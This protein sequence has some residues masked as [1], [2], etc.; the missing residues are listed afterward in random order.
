M[1]KSKMKYVW[2]SGLFMIGSP[3]YAKAITPYGESYTLIEETSGYASNGNIINYIVDGEIKHATISL[4]LSTDNYTLTPNS[5]GAVTILGT[6]YDVS[7]DNGVDYIG[8]VNTPKSITGNI[9]SN[10]IGNTNN[11]DGAAIILSSGNGKTIKGNFISNFSTGDGAGIYNGGLGY[12]TSIQGDFIDNTVSSSGSVFGGAIYNQG[13]VSG[14]DKSLKIKGIFANNKIESTGGDAKGGA[15]YN[16]YKPTSSTDAQLISITDSIFSNNKAS[17]SSAVTV[18]GGAIYHTGNALSITNTSFIGNSIS[19]I[20]AEARGGAISIYTAESKSFVISNSY[21]SKNTINISNEGVKDKARGGAIYLETTAL[22]DLKITDTSFVDNFAYDGA[23]IANLVHG[24]TTTIYADQKDVLFDNMSTGVNSGIY[25]Q[26]DSPLILNANNEKTLTIK[27]KIVSEGYVKIGLEINKNST[28]TGTILLT[29][30]LPT[31]TEIDLNYGTLHLQDDAATS[32][33][34]SI[35]TNISNQAILSTQ[36]S[37]I[38]TLSMTDLLA[39]SGT[40]LNY[41]FDLNLNTKKSDILSITNA[42]SAITI[43]ISDI[44][45]LADGGNATGIRFIEASSG[46]LG[47]FTLDTNPLTVNTENYEYTITPVSTTASSGYFSLNVKQAERVYTLPELIADSSKASFSMTGDLQPKE[48]LGT[49]AGANR[50]FTINGNNHTLSGLAENGSTRL[51]G[52]VTDSKNQTLTVNSLTVQYYT[53][54]A[55]IK[56]GDTLNLQDVVF[57]NNEDDI[58]NAGTVN[59]A[60]TNSFA[61]GV[62]GT[63]LM[64]ISSGTTNFSSTAGLQQGNLTVSS[65]A[66]LKI[67]PANLSITNAV[68]NNGI[69]DFGYDGTLTQMIKGDGTLKV[70]ANLTVDADNLFQNISTN[71]GSVN[72]TGGSLLKTIE[73]TTVIAS[74]TVNSPL[75]NF[76]GTLTN[77]ATLNLADNLTKNIAG[78]GTTV[79]QSDNVEVTTATTVAGTLDLNNK[80]L[81]MQN[82]VSNNVLTIGNLIGTGNLKIDADLT[83]KNADYLSLSGG[84]GTIT[85][86]DISI[87]NP[88]QIDT[89]L[90]I[91]SASDSSNLNFIVDVDDKEIAGYTYKFTTNSFGVLSISRSIENL[92]FEDFITGTEKGK[93]VLIFD[94]SANQSVTA[95]L[96]TNRD[97]EFTLNMNEKSLVGEDNNGITVKSGDEFHIV[98]NGVVTGFSTALTNNGTLVIQNITFED[99]TIDISN[100]G[101]LNLTGINSFSSGITGTGSTEIKSGTTTFSSDANLNQTNLTI[102]MGSILNVSSNNLVISGTLTNNGTLNLAGNLTKDISGS[103]TTV[104]Q[105]DISIASNISISGTLNINE[106]TIDMENDPAVF[107]TLTVGVMTGTGNLKIDADLNTKETDKINAAEFDSATLNLT[108]IHISNGYAS[109]NFLPQDDY[110]TVLTNAGSLVLTNPIKNQFGDYLYTFENGTT[111]GKLKVTQKYNVLTL[112]DYITGTEKGLEVSGEF[113]LAGDINQTSA[114]T[115]GSESSAKNPYTIAL[116]GYAINGD[117]QNNDGITV[118]SGMELTLYGDPTSK[119]TISNFYT[120]LINSGTLN[121]SDVNFTGNNNDIVNNGTLNISGV[122]SFTTGILSTGGGITNSGVVNLGYSGTIDIDYL[123]TGTLNLNGNFTINNKIYNNLSVGSGYT[124]QIKPENLLGTVDNNGTI[125]LSDGIL[126]QSLNGKVII[127]GTVET[128]LSKLTGTIT[129]NGILKLNGDLTK[130]ILGTLGKT[131]LQ[132]ANVNVTNEVKIDGVLDMNNKTLNMA[133]GVAGDNLTIGSFIGTGTL[134]LDVDLTGNLIDKITISDGSQ[135]GTNATL[136]LSL[137]NL[138]NEVKTQD[139][140]FIYGDNAGVEFSLDK[141]KYLSADYQYVASINGNI[142]RIVSSVIDPGDLEIT[143]IPN[144]FVL[145]TETV[146]A[147]NFEINGDIIVLFD[148]PDNTGKFYATR[149]IEIKEKTHLDIAVNKLSLVDQPHIL[150]LADNNINVASVARQGSSGRVSYTISHDGIL[151]ITNVKT[152]TEMVKMSGGS[153]RQAKTAEAWDGIQMNQITTEGKIAT[154][155]AIL[156]S[157]G[158]SSYIRALNKLAPQ[159]SVAVLSQTETMNDIANISMTQA[160]IMGK[161]A[162]FENL[163]GNVWAKGLLNHAK[164]SHSNGFK[165]DNTGFATG[166]DI[167]ASDDFKM[168]IGYGYRYFC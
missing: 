42:A 81:D 23:A 155:L 41:A 150:F 91:I 58:A 16:T 75:S 104:L 160:G 95:S 101:T 162:G 105:S 65:G 161:S 78:T 99:N 110:L 115:T 3:H 14:S 128:D 82:S 92:T 142:L 36:D 118:A 148:R 63:G 139:F 9:T 154:K 21:F 127:G 157:K 88:T 25:I 30:V 44:K 33:I 140:Q 83:A 168:G 119:G 73:G 61:S 45:I 28:N 165:A 60:G 4:N 96:E 124:V 74:G 24:W 84:T 43:K 22:G 68:S 39:E 103:G 113:E 143:K 93:L 130:N 47:N 48:A 106:K 12:F 136:N 31:A 131:I 141:N 163:K 122:V 19:S 18:Q 98:G 138:W 71:T 129:N 114:I 146:T 107:N 109:E 64:T 50:T 20:D 125:Y 167:D 66:T 2:L 26:Y 159:N 11:T 37:K 29:Q 85:L 53:T 49:L 59:L 123:G 116:N 166:V 147:D 76:K 32:T 62:T 144:H 17:S 112:A 111:A 57:S 54:F 67:N 135:N 97:D 164:M 51:A 90:T 13:T 152:A 7:D 117:S 77:N 100:A 132:S 102:D 38:G 133:N 153:S 87:L 121:I 89:G 79:L 8:K 46:I 108:G 27:D 126:S 15:I 6:K 86:T 149:N 10:F 137:L 55:N 35:K 80:T 56:T 151:N 120:A 94:L 145:G 69:I 34:K 5:S 40:T 72:L 134:K 1:L 158:G 156:S 52:V 70:S